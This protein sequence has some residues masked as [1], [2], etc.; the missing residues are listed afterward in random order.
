MTVKDA[1]RLTVVRE[2]QLENS[3]CPICSTPS[4]KVTVT[5]PWQVA[6]ASSPTF[7]TLPGIVISVRALQPAKTRLPSSVT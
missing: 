3:F 2:P 4:S 1:G 5:R 7:F 6:N